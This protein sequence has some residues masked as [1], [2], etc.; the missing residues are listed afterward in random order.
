MTSGLKI[1]SSLTKQCGIKVRKAVWV[2]CGPVVVGPVGE[3]GW[4]KKG[5]GSGTSPTRQKLCLNLWAAPHHA[6][7]RL[8]WSTHLVALPNWHG[9]WNCESV[10]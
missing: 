1:V 10:T 9:N 3:M 8:A 6:L 2:K 5:G 4:T 7:V